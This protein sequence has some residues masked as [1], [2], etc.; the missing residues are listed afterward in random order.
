MIR[1]RHS[2]STLL[3]RMENKG[4]IKRTQDRV[5]KNLLRISITEKGKQAYKTVTKLESVHL[6]ESVLSTEE[7][8]QMVSNLKKLR[9]RGVKER[10]MDYTPAFP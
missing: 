3:Q 1:E 5:R 9:D 7:R 6:I 8:R 10:G 4:L 2:V